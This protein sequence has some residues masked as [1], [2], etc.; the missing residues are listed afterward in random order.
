MDT[1]GHA[2]KKLIKS[3]MAEKYNLYPFMTLDNIDIQARIH[4]TRIESTTKMF[5]GSYGYLHFL[6]GHLTK[7]IDPN[8]ATVENLLKCVEKSQSEPFE[9]SSMLPDQKDDAHWTL[10]LKS[11][12]AEALVEYEVTPNSAAHIACKESLALANHTSSRSSG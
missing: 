12:L 9:P 11:Q 6:P 1:L 4:N 7:D 2:C 5:H 10:V 3:R 8:E